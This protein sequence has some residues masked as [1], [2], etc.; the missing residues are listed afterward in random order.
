VSRLRTAAKKVRRKPNDNTATVYDTIISLENETENETEELVMC[1][2]DSFFVSSE[3]AV[4]AAVREED[5]GHIDIEQQ[6][7]QSMEPCDV[8]LEVVRVPC[9]HVFHRSC[10]LQWSI[11]SRRTCPVCRKRVDGQ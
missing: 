6:L 5:H 3:R 8:P 2:V 4:V 1:P 10:I 7:V 9:G 11:S